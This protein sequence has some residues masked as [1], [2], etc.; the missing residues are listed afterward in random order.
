MFTSA[1]TSY[2][3]IESYIRDAWNGKCP[4]VLL[5]KIGPYNIFLGDIARTAPNQE[6]ESEIVNACLFILVRRFNQNHQQ[7]A[8]CINSFEMSSIWRH[9][10]TKLKIDPRNFDIVLGIINENHHWMLMV[11]FPHKEK[12]LL[13]DPLKATPWK[14]TRCLQSTRKF[15][16]GKGCSVEKWTCETLHH[17]VQ[18]D[19]TSCGVFCLKFAECVLCNDTLP[20]HFLQ[21]IMT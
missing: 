10:K 2:D 8:L 6:L 1:S 16:K 4:H 15:M 3:K 20:Y 18:R 17:P 19:S 12:T 7:Q 11:F 9:E 13:L 14:I 21:V 5:S